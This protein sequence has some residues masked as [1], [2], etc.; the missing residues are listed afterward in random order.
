MALT[1]YVI[2]A[3]VGAVLV[4]LG[5]GLIFLPAGLIVAGGESLAGAYI[6][7]YLHRGAAS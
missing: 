2:L 7:V 5:A 3:V 4:A 6:G 1:V